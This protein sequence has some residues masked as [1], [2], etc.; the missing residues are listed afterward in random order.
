MTENKVLEFEFGTRSEATGELTKQQLEC[1]DHEIQIIS[2]PTESQ[3][4]QGNL[5]LRKP[6]RVILRI[7]RVN[8]LL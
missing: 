8:C 2:R 1:L 3:E 6:Q 5:G 4:I 7:Q